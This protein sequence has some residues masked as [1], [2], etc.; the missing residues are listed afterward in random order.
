VIDK[1]QALW[2]HLKPSQ[3]ALVARLYH[4]GVVHDLAPGAKTNTSAGVRA[5]RLRQ[6]MGADAI[7]SHGWSLSPEALAAIKGA[8]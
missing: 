7:R 1:I 4:E 2:P 6:V 5:Y 8:P 3:V